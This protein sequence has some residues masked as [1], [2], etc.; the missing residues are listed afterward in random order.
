M[1]QNIQVHTGNRIAVVFDGKAIGAISSVRGNFDLSPEPVLGIGDINV[2]EHAPTVARHSLS[3]SQMVL[4][5]EN[6]INAG[7]SVENGDAALRGLVFDIEVY[8]KDSGK[9]LRKWTGV[10]YASGDI[11][12]SANRITV[13]SGQFNALDATGLF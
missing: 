12:I 5:K 7:I 9:Q 8:D 11:D 1:K 3:I 2:I 4:K 6:M 10:S 13:A